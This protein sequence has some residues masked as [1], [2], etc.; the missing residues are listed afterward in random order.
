MRSESKVERGRALRATLG[1]A[2]VAAF[3]AA[4]SAVS[5]AGPGAEMR[6]L[7]DPA[8]GCRFVA[9]ASLA[10]EPIHW[11]G[12]CPGGKASGLGMLRSRTGAKA[13]HAF[14]GE[15][16]DGVPVIGAIDFDDGFRVGRFVDGDIGTRDTEWQQRH[17]GFEA[18]LRAARRVGDHYAAQNNAASARHYR[19]VAKKLETQLEGD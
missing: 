13:G 19:A 18:A 1:G 16:R 15:L 10:A 7:Q 3:V 14:Y 8:T 11:T 4:S 5:A 12:G 17:D 9:P 2:A 6:W